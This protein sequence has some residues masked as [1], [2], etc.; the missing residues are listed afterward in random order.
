[1]VRAQSGYGEENPAKITVLLFWGWVLERNLECDISVFRVQIASII[2]DFVLEIWTIHNVS[3]FFYGDFPMVY[4]MIERCGDLK[5][6]LGVHFWR[7]L[8]QSVGGFATNPFDLYRFL[9][10]MIEIEIVRVVLG[11][12]G[13][14]KCGK[15]SIRVL[16]TKP[17]KNNRPTVF[18]LSF[19]T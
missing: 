15:D 12:V 4:E 19:R 18:V 3:R 8:L 5:E 17:S 1:M 10:A 9:R 7:I 16:W 13:R 14:F 2:L 11:R 6:Q